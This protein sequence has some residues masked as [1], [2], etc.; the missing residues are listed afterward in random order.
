[1]PVSVQTPINKYTANGVTTVFAYQFLVLDEADLTVYVDDVET[2]TGFTVA[3]V[4]D[5]SGGSVT[6]AVAPASESVIT[7]LRDMLPVR[8]TDYQNSGDF[9]AD[10]VNS[11]FDR[12]WLYMQYLQNVF[13][14]RAL[15]FPEYANRTDTQN[16][17]PA[18]LVPGQLLQVQADQSVAGVEVTTIG[19]DLSF[20]TAEIIYD[21]MAA[22]IASSDDVSTAV[23]RAFY[24]SSDKGRCRVYKIGSGF[25]PTDTTS[26]ATILV[27]WA[28]GF[29]VNQAGIKFGIPKDQRISQSI[30]GAYSN[31]NG[32][33]GADDTAAIKAMLS[34]V[35]DSMDT[36]S[37]AYP[38]F[39]DPGICK[40]SER[41]D[42][43]PGVHIFG[44]GIYNGTQ[45]VSGS[46]I[47]LTHDGVGFR[48]VRA[49]AGTTLYHN[50]AMR[51]MWFT[52]NGSSD[53]AATRLVELGSSDDVDAN[54]GAWN[55]II[56]NCAFN[57]TYG[58]GIYS[59]HSQSWKIQRNFFRNVRYGIWY[60]T[61]TASAVISDNE[62]AFTNAG[63]NGYGIVLLRGSLGGASGAIVQNNYMISPVVG[64]WLSNQI[65]AQVD[66]NTIEGAKQEAIVMHRNL[67]SGSADTTESSPFLQGC[68]GCSL[69]GNTLINWNADGGSKFAIHLY[70]SRNNYIGHQN[71]TSPNGA[72]PGGIGLTT[73]GTDPTNNNIIV[74]PIIQGANS[75]TVP[76]FDSTDT[77]WQSQ[78]M[79]RQDGIKLALN[80][81]TGTR[82]VADKGHL[83]MDANNILFW[84]GS[85]SR[86]VL[87]PESALAGAAGA[88]TAW[89]RINHNGTNYKLPLYLDS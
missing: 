23:L 40:I 7:I 45:V 2:T 38:V 15:L 44:S 52:G 83:F 17:L 84:D 8:E 53:T 79:I 60:N 49:S 9:R 54:N 81:Y 89:L 4:G 59:A 25:T 73:D 20:A 69:K 57:S 56:E 61:V 34:Y 36:P 29:Y 31:Y 1:M 43:P 86:R 12:I 65:G 71:Y 21:S 72:S 68:K 26:L 30:F 67:P 66:N 82:G 55:G 28:Q 64:I 11:D 74:Q 14:K 32:V 58:Y 87:A 10:T 77:T 27:D 6:F 41:I 62:M 16:S 48:F 22:A 76:G 50:G 24:A 63:L 70:Y 85:T 33:T 78:T 35:S 42:V 3:G 18:V 5:A 51:Y 37:K 46:G 19:S 39:F 80:A 47:W 88:Q 13:N 75:T